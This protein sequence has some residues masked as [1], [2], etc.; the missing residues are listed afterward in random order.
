M[1]NRCMPLGR[2][3]RRTALPL[4]LVGSLV[5]AACQATGAPSSSDGPRSPSTSA[6]AGLQAN[7]VGAGATFPDP[8]YQEWIGAFTTENPGVSITYEPIGSGGGVEQ[9]IAGSTDFGGSDAFMT[10]DELAAA[11]KAH[12]CA[13]VHI[14]T[15]FGAVAVAYNL[16]GVEG[17]VLDS[18][19][20]ANIFLGEI[21]TW[22]DPAIAALNPNATLPATDIIVAH[23]SDGSGTTSIFTTYLDGESG[24]WHDA[25]GKG[26]EVSW[27]TGVGGQGND[28]VAA[29]IAQNEGGIGYVELSY[30]IENSL[31]VASVKNADGMAIEPTLEST[32]A[33]A[34]G[35][36]IPEDLRFNISG[37]AGKGYP[38]AGATWVLAYTCGYDA[39][40]ADALKAFLRWSLENG[41][42]IARQLHY[43][44]IGEALQVRALANVD[45]INADG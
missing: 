13:A 7:L 2:R 44:P 36:E 35:I 23:R 33:A 10:D 41:D 30:A 1:T 8:V 18:S 6:G 26:K 27:P 12:G 11:E 14:P 4:L 5:L 22:N 24:Q 17:L 42:D 29:A 40:K 9:F 43:A 28:G 3:A 39:A 25:V 31:T 20:I 16:P 19:A 21:K 15:V 34:D 32:A 37:V 38:I 45:R